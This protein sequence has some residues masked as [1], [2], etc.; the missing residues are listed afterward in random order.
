[1]TTDRIDA[2]LP[3]TLKREENACNDSDSDINSDNI[4]DFSSVLL[5][6]LSKNNSVIINES[7]NEFLRLTT[8]A[9]FLVYIYSYDFLALKKKS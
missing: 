5:P 7:N 6:S 4:A 3:F 9:R 2:S 1:M 8:M